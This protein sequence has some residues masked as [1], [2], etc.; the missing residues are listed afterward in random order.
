VTLVIVGTFVF[1]A[2][3]LVIHELRQPRWIRHAKPAE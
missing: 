2:I 1:C 3:P